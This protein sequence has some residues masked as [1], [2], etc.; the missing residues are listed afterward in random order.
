MDN[1]AIETHQLTRRYESVAVVDALD[2]R[3]DYG[4]IAAGLEG[5]S[6]PAEGS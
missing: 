2:L 6:G 4:L 3:V 1:A 5:S